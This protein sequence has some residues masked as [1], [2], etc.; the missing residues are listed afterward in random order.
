MVAAAADAK[1]FPLETGA[2]CGGGTLIRWEAG[3]RRGCELVWLGLLLRQSDRGK[4]ERD[5][6][7]RKNV[8]VLIQV[9]KPTEGSQKV[10]TYSRYRNVDAEQHCN[11][12][13]SKCDSGSKC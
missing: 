2:E 3:R 10:S 8:V 11:S 13:A 7:E 12:G 4:G 5:L 9:R 6:G 1:W